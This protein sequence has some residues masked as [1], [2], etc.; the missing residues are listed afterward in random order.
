MLGGEVTCALWRRLAS[1]PFPMR[2]VRLDTCCD[3]LLFFVC[4]LTIACL[5]VCVHMKLVSR[6]RGVVTS[7]LDRRT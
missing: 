1:L 4:V 3:I 7:A 5:S 6:C 2:L